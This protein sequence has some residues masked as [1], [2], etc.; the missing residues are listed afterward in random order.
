MKHCLTFPKTL[1][2]A[3]DIIER[4]RVRN[5]YKVVDYKVYPWDYRERCRKNITPERIV[6]AA[7]KVA[8]GSDNTFVGELSP[9]HV[10]VNL[11]PLHYGMEDK[12]PLEFVRFY[13]KHS[14]MVA[15]LGSR[16]TISSLMPDSFGEVLLRILT[17]EARFFGIIQRAYRELVQTAF[18]ETED[19]WF[20]EPS[21]VLTPTPEPPSTPRQ[22]K[23]TF[24]RNLSLGSL[25]ERDLAR[26]NPFT[27]AQ[28]SPLILNIDNRKRQRNEIGREGSPPHKRKAM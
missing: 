22:N 28:N 21:G 11:S 18:N 3:R 17:K 14:P 8:S 23:R 16:D 13:S 26:P 20:P 5:L 4:I 25:S 24:S 1:Q 2:E 9:S 10:I 19:I 15:H 27:D 12:N 7:R 6:E